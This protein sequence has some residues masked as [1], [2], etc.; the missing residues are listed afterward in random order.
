MKIIRFSNIPYTPASHEDP[1][2]PGVLKK[3]LLHADSF[4]GGHVQM[5]NWATLGVAKGFT[6]HYHE[7]MQEVFIIVNGKA[8]IQIDHEQARLE[9][10][11]AVVVPIGAMHTMDNIG[12]GDVDYIAIGVA[13]GN[14]GKTVVVSDI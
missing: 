6:P 10:G 13:L 5:I 7:D 14:N 2:H 9:P 12:D 1:S 11:D 3:V 8:R 4:V